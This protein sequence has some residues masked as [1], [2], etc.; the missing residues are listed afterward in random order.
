MRFQG[1]VVIVTGASKGIGA[2]IARAF[3]A[4]G[5]RVVVNYA[6]GK[7]DA[8]RVVADIVAR[9]GKAIAVQGDVSRA[10]DV[11]R[12]FAETRRQFG[13]LDVLVNNAGVFAFAPLEEVTEAEFHRQFDIN[14]LG[15]LLATREALK[16]FGP[17]GGSV[18]NVSSVGSENPPQGSS[19]YTATKGAIDT[20]T[21]TLARELAP[22]KIR[23]NS[24]S[25]GATLTEGVRSSGLADSPFVQRY[26][27][28]TPLGRL[29]APE[30]MGG[31]AL[32]LASPD[33]AWVTGEKIVVSGGLR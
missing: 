32:F 26:V 27:A 24:I 14:V 17:E 8:E 29:G 16:L 25:P 22:R 13:R 12:L 20:L 28:D 6:R 23:V 19:V 30:D 5:A 31:V 10:D 4:E 2:G 3:G 1:K 11:S 7:E 33:S 9:D 21:R 18:I 15:T